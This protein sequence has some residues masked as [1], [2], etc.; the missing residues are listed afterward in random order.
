M[1]LRQLLTLLILPAA[2]LVAVAPDEAIAQTDAAKPVTIAERVAAARFSPGML[3][4]DR[5]AAKPFTRLQPASG[6]SRDSLKNGALIGAIVGAVALGGLGA[7]VCQSFRE[8]TDP[9]CLGSTLRIAAVGAAIGLGAG[10]AVDAA[11]THNAGARVAVR[12]RF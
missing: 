6:G 9:S 10:V 1:Y 7:A 2:L 11:L 4:P 12:V 8:P 5:S 3:K